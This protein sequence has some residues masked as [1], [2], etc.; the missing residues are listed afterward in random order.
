MAVK[1]V[2]YKVLI[3]EMEQVLASKPATESAEQ[4]ADDL[5]RKADK[6][7][8]DRKYVVRSFQ[9]YQT[10]QQPDAQARLQRLHHRLLRF[11]RQPA[12]RRNGRSRPA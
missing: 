6:S 1:T 5:L 7:F 3:D 9:F 8:I 12:C 2:S 11:L 4:A 10:V